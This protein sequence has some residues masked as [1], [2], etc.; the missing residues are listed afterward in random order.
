LGGGY[1]GGIIFIQA[2]TLVSN[3]FTI[4]ANGSA[5]GNTTGD[6]ASGGG[7]GG[8]II[9]S[10]ANFT[11]AVFI[12]AKGGNGGQEDDEAISGR[13]Y[14]EGGGG[15][16]GVI[17]FSGTQPSGTVDV[18]GGAKGVKINSTC[19]SA[20]GANGNAGSL[21]TNY[22]YME[23]TTLSGC[24]ATVLDAGW[25]YFKISTA[26]NT[27]LLQWAVTG[28]NNAY[29]L[30][31]RQQKEDNWI[32]IARIATSTNRTEYSF[33][34][35][36]LAPGTYLYRLKA[37]NNQ[38]TSYS[39]I[40]QVTIKGN[41]QVIYYDDITQQ[42]LVRNIDKGDMLQVFD[43]SGRCVFRKRFMSNTAEWRL[44]ASFLQNGAYA[45]KTLKASTKFIVARK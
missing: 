43:F 25:L 17:Y 23:S 6:G 18:S 2:Q 8:T 1:G 29:F 11:D 19:A 37:V 39:F 3:G 36:Y 27:V 9:L 26:A 40:N 31:E 24:S 7:G 32:D 33:L 10:V 16:G 22:G 4:S 5:G 12:E 20:T 45:A 28:N 38:K 44:P 15:S 13:C 21:F 41:E 30:V 34:D 14:G 35:S 42:V